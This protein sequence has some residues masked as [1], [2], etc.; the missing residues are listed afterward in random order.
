M[1][2][3]TYVYVVFSKTVQEPDESP[4]QKSTIIGMMCLCIALSLAG[5]FSTNWSEWEGGHSSL[6]TTY[7]DE[8]FEDADGQTTSQE[9]FSEDE[10]WWCSML[11]EFDNEDWAVEVCDKLRVQKNAGS[12][13]SI[14]L[15][16]STATGTWFLVVAYRSIGG[17]KQNLSLAILDH[18]FCLATGG[19]MVSSSLIWRVMMN[20]IIND[21]ERS[22]G[23]GFYITLV[24]RLIGIV[25]FAMILR[26]HPE[27]SE[28][29]DR[30][31]SRIQQENE[32]KA[33]AE[34]DAKAVAEAAAKDSE[35]LQR[36]E[37]AVRAKREAEANPNDP[38]SWL[39]MAEAMDAANRHEEAE[40]CRKTAMELMEKETL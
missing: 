5:Q 28:M 31:K 38:L 24:G 19:L 4:S 35:L 20:D 40:R 37:E 7:W 15:W 23:S 26:V 1:S 2:L 14:L 25:A 12:L 13:A 36:T 33:K 11:P 21:W 30:E 9:T 3:N 10:N 18:R 34:A 17:I 32:A 22:L 27:M 6:D 8:E 16:I 29:L 39:R